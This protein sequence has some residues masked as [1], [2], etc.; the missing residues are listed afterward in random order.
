MFLASAAY[1]LLLQNEIMNGL[2]YLTNCV[3]LF[4][5]LEHCIALWV[6]EDVM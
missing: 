2:E 3:V 6:A 4:E 1:L 5:K